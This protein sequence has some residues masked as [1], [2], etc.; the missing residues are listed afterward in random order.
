[1]RILITT[2]VVILLTGAVF[3][4]FWSGSQGFGAHQA[5]EFFPYDEEVALDT[6]ETIRSSGVT[7]LVNHFEAA[8]TDQDMA[9]LMQAAYRMYPKQCSGYNWEIAVRRPN[10]DGS[11]EKYSYSAS[12]YEIGGPGSWIEIGYWTN[13]H[14]VITESHES[15]WEEIDRI[16]R[17][18]G[19]FKLL[20]KGD[21]DL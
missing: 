4:I 20:E 6:G 21:S 2:G 7:V 5:V 11:E 15:N 19:I 16:A 1:M 12:I 8:P 17:G 13:E 18:N 3:G 9:N 14:Y 10:P